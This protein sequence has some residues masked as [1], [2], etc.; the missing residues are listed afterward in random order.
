MADAAQEAHGQIRALVWRDYD[1]FIRAIRDDRAL[2]PVPELE[3]HFDRY[4]GGPTL[5][6][7][8]EDVSGLQ[9]AK[10]SEMVGQDFDVR[11]EGG[12][13]EVFCPAWPPD[14]IPF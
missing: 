14:A 6:I 9:I 2:G 4:G 13:L 3:I 8:E 10:L 12:R 1:R 7:A 5:R 11:L